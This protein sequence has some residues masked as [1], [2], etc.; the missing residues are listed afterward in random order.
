M[1]TKKSKHFQPCLGC[2]PVL[3]IYHKQDNLEDG[4][5]LAIAP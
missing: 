1:T 5:E 2:H 3:Q 4:Y